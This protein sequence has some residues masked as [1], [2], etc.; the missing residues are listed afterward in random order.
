MEPR[1]KYERTL[2]LCGAACAAALMLI[3]VWPH[4]ISG[5]IKAPYEDTLRDIARGKTV[6]PVIIAETETALR[7]SQKWVQTGEISIALGGMRFLVARNAQSAVAQRATLDQSIS[8]LK[9]GLS[10]RPA[11]PY[12]WLQLA[13]AERVRNGATPSLEKYL[14]FSMRIAPWEHRL[15]LPRLNVALGAWSALSDPFKARLPGQFERAIDTAPLQLAKVARRN[16]ALR[17]VRK[18]LAAS[19]VHL[20]RFLIVYLSPD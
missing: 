13:Q 8:A 16:F 7:V 5:A 2:V 11:Q 10:R 9:R 20:E 14:D 6:P 17:A 18:M 3:A 1:T 15:V 12:A 4:F 19:P